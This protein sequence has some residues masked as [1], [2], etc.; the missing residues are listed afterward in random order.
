MKISYLCKRCCDEKGMHFNGIAENQVGRKA[1][2]NCGN[3]QDWELHVV[4]EPDV[5]AIDE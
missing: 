3:N 5:E 1:C 4:S 2:G